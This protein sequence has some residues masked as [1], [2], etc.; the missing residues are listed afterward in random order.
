[1]EKYAVVHLYLDRDKMG[2][3]CTQKAL[4]WSSKFKDQSHRYAKHKDLNDYLI[5]SVNP[6]LK[7]TRSKGMRL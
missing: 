5:K 2:L 4:E 6:G 3:Q 1:M 7:Q